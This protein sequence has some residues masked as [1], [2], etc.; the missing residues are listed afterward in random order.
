MKAAAQVV[1]YCETLA[2]TDVSYLDVSVYDIVVMAIAKSFK[3]LSHVVT[4]K[5]SKCETTQ[6]DGGE[7]ESM[8][9]G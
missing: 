8:D 1:L 4:K 3:Y 6:R 2:L 5:Q 7:T 9:D